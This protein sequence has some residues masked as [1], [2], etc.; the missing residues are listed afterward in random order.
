MV[1]VTWLE[2]K[3]SH[4]R[5]PLRASAPTPTRPRR[6]GGSSKD[7]ILHMVG[8]FVCIDDHMCFCVVR[9][10]VQGVQEH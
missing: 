4:L 5:T 9:V 1:G 3:L 6:L 10:A 7:T 2:E 8:R